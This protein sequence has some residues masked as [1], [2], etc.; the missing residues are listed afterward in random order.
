MNILRK[1][2]QEL[3][4]FV[5]ML[6]VILAFALPAYANPW[7]TGKQAR[8]AAATTTQV[9]LV[10]GQATSSPIYDAYEVGGTNQIN[11]GDISLP[12]FVSVLLAGRSTTTASQVSVT[13]EFSD[14]YNTVTGNGDW[15]QNEIYDATTTGPQNI[16]APISQRFTYSSSSNAIGGAAVTATSDRFQ[17]LVICPTPLRFTRAIVTTTGATSSLWIAII[18][19]K[20]R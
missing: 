9:T 7:F 6:V 10:P 2:Y 18:P 19:K 11:S 4:L 16:D 15:F 3:S 20:Q 5:L 12:D 17:K 14:N 8:T 1:H 13:C